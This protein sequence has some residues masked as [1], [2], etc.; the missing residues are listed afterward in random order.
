MQ[1]R[2]LPKLYPF[3]QESS[4]RYRCLRYLELYRCLRYLE[5]TLF[6][7][8]FFSASLYSVIFSSA[9]FEEKVKILS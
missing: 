8:I 3:I 4:L 2:N 1:I 9:V 7:M 6:T 5:L